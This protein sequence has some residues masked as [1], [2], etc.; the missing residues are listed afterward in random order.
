MRKPKE[1]PMM[2]HYCTH[3]YD[4]VQGA[5]SQRFLVS[6]VCLILFEF[7]GAARARLS[8]IRKA[9]SVVS[10]E[11]EASYSKSSGIGQPVI[12]YDVTT[13]GVSPSR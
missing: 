1:Q 4:N 10:E 9:F 13:M 2:G 7:S 12:R 11:P 3:E 8:S 5:P 6:P